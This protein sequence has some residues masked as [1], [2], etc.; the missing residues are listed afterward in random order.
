VRNQ[1][2]VPL[3]IVWPPELIEADPPFRLPKLSK[4]SAAP[5]FSSSPLSLANHSLSRFWLTAHDGEDA[6]SVGTRSNANDQTKGCSR[7]Q[8][9][10]IDILQMPRPI[11][12]PGDFCNRLRAANSS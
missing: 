10:R 6:T 11:S 12:H 4:A 2:D 7:R 5:N 3:R 9:S 8:S 1:V